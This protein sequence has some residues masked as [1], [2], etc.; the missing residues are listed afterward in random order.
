MSWSAHTLP[1]TVTPF[2]DGG[3]RVLLHW[4]PQHLAWLAERGADGLLA[5]G[6][7]GEGPSLNLEER[8]QI[9]DVIMEH[10]GGLATVFGTGCASLPETAEVSRYALERG[11]DAVL[12]VPPFYFK[13]VPAD[14]LIAY[15]DALLRA[16]PSERKVLLYN[17][18]FLSGVEVSDEL[19][20]ALAERFPER[21]LGVK[22]TS[23]H[24]ERT[25]G[26]VRRYPQLTILCGS[27]HL[28]GPAYRA[29]AVG[30]ISGLANAFPGLMSAVWLAHAEGGDV[31]AAQER[32]Q[33]AQGLL[34]GL[35]A[36]SA[37]KHL[38]HLMAGLPLTYVRPPL[39]DLTRDET[40][41]LRRRAS[42]MGL[43]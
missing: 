40:E 9:I 36:H 5:M 37:M 12:I 33:E 2:A 39:R 25:E 29:G 43:L 11:A 22:D 1:A 41:E 18:P 34:R 32:V 35:P 28:A 19:M 30:S 23:G 16:L 26:Y 42:E 8:K 6:T 15:F 7:N 31:D 17:I 27:D 3:E 21:L 13:G 10:R 20:D 14:G 4:I 38:L 24:L